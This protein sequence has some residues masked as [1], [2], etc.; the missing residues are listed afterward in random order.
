MDFNK[1]ALFPLLL[2]ATLVSTTT[3][4]NKEGMK[5]RAGKEQEEEKKEVVEDKVF[6]VELS[7][8]QLSVFE[9]QLLSNGKLKAY[10]NVALRFKE[11]EPITKVHVRNGQRVAKGQL[12]AELDATQANL[13]LE[14]A[15]SNLEKAELNLLDY[16][17]AFDPDIKTLEDTN[18]VSAEVLRTAKIRQGYDDAILEYNDAKRRVKDC[19]LFAPFT[20]VVANIKLEEGNYPS[21]DFCNV[22]YSDRL[23]VEFQM[24]ES[25]L[26]DLALGQKVEVTPFALKQGFSGKITEIN[27]VISEKGMVG[28]TAVIVNEQNRLMEGMNASVVI[29]KEL[30]NKITIPKNTI[31]LRDNKQGVF[32]AGKDS[33][34][35]TISL[36]KPI[37]LGEEN[38]SE[39]IVTE[40]LAEGEELIVK[41]LFNLGDSSKITTEVI[42]TKL[43]VKTE[44]QQ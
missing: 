4:C 1:K 7:P 11:T 6:Q 17:I 30:P 37:Q 3:S 41:G 40:G 33:I 38:A 24:M 39:Y 5:G 13:A 15:K 16:L 22:I 10:R 36:W 8:V 19:K 32:V 9:R 20:G 29:A 12:I 27:P 35:Q 43:E 42:T 26:K 25:E 2:G 18:K 14:R 21:G 31:V 23:K 34:D 28:V 44:E